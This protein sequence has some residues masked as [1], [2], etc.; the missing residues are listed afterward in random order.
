MKERGVIIRLIF[1]SIIL[2]LSGCTIDS[3]E[4]SYDNIIPNG[5]YVCS[6]GEK[7]FTSIQD[8]ID[9]ADTGQTIF[10][11]SGVYDERLIINKTINLIGEDPKST[12]ID[13]KKLGRVLIITDEGFCTITG[14][15]IQ[16]SMSNVPG[17]EIKA[18]NNNISNN[19]IKDTYIGINSVGSNHNYLYNNTFISNTMYAIYIG[20]RSDYNVINKNVLEDNSYGLRIKGS[21]HNQVVGNEFRNNRR[22]IYLCCGSSGNIV[23]HNNFVNNSVWSARDDVTGNVWYNI[24]LNQGNYWEDYDGI[25]ENN[26]S[27]G[28]TPYN[29]NTDGSRK[30]LYPLMLP[31]D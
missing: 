4:K 31:L 17:I 7:E 12:I 14:F 6:S 21:Q 26:D 11:F 16:N 5:L 29:I 9:T 27:I 1:L 19:I 23:Y 28:D 20:S 22:G 30:D 15:T 25:D 13:G 3:S 10:V 18:S 24:E 8:A 2:F